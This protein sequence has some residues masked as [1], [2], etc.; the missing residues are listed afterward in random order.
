MNKTVTAFDSMDFESSGQGSLVKYTTEFSIHG[1]AKILQPLL[2][3]AFTSLRD[4][5]LN[6]IRDTLNS[7]AAR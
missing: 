7:L 5:V 3:P 4:P 2:K 1:P 6:G